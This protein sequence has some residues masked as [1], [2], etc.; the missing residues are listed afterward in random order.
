M[1]DQEATTLSDEEVEAADEFGNE[2]F[3]KMIV[4]AKQ[5]GV[6][7]SGVV[8]SLFVN[9]AHLLASAGWTPGELAKEAVDHATA[10]INYEVGS[11]AEEAFGL[12]P[13]G[14]A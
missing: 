7:V 10:Q 14:S 11:E 1:A 6:D 3:D 4:E 8:F 12:V 5:K 2:L 13:Q 9:A